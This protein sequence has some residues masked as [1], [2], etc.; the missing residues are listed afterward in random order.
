MEA[1]SDVRMKA[2]GMEAAQEDEAMVEGIRGKLHGQE[3]DPALVQLGQDAELMQRLEVLKQEL[4]KEKD[5]TDEARMEKITAWMDTHGIAEADLEQAISRM[6]SAVGDPARAPRLLP[7]LRGTDWER[8]A[9][10]TLMNAQSELARTDPKAALRAFE[11][12]APGVD[13]EALRNAQ[14]SYARD[15]SKARRTHLEN[16]F[17]VEEYDA[18]NE[19]YLHGTRD[20]SEAVRAWREDAL[21]AEVAPQEHE[22]FREKLREAYTK[23]LEGARDEKDLAER[24]ATVPSDLLPAAKVLVNS[25]FRTQPGTKEQARRSESV[26]SVLRDHPEALVED[27]SLVHGAVFTDEDRGRVFKALA[28]R[29]E[30]SPLVG[31]FS[32]DRLPDDLRE[33][34][35]PLI[36]AQRLRE[37]PASIVSELEQ[38]RQEFDALSEEQRLDIFR[39]AAGKDPKAVLAQ[40]DAIPSGDA[41]K[42]IVA[43]AISRIASVDFRFFKAQKDR[44]MSLPVEE[45]ARIAD[46]WL[47]SEGLRGHEVLPHLTWQASLDKLE[48]LQA[49]AANAEHDPWRT[50]LEPLLTEAAHAGVIDTH[51]EADG[52]IVVDFVKQFGMLNMPHVFDWHAALSR[53]KDIK[54]LAPD[55]RADLSAFLGRPVEKLPNKGFI[56]Q[57]IKRVSAEL[58]QALL[59]G[60]LSAEMLRRHPAC[61]EMV[62]AAIGTTMWG[63]GRNFADLQEKWERNVAAHPEQLGLPEG[64]ETVRLEVAE[65]ERGRSRSDDEKKEKIVNNPD[66]KRQVEQWQAS[67][68]ESVRTPGKLLNPFTDKPSDGEWRGAMAEMMREEIA[69]ELEELGQKADSLPNEKARQG[70]EKKRQELKRVQDAISRALEPGPGG[71]AAPLRP[72]TDILTEIAS[73]PKSFSKKGELLRYISA[74]HMQGLMS[75]ERRQLAY[76]DDA[77]SWNSLMVDYVNEHYLNE[78]QQ[79]DHTGHEPF[80]PKTLEALRFAWGL[81]K[82]ETNPVLIAAERLRE[83]EQGKATGKTKTVDLVPVTGLMRITAGDAGDACY[84]SKHDGL[85]EGQYPDLQAFVFVTGRGT[86]QERIQGSVLAVETV[87]DAGNKTLVVRANNPRMSLLSAVDPAQLI[88]QTLEALKATAARRGIA[89]VVVP[90]DAASSSCSNRA[91][92]ADHY[93]EMYGQGSLAPAAIVGLRRQPETEFN[94]YDNWDKYGHHPVVRI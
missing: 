63:R 44:V 33:E 6:E 40:E 55:V 11:R 2:M 30:K 86:P 50:D 12:S 3:Q 13:E 79:P 5:L 48:S 88:A 64:Y 31:R 20:P 17:T 16:L 58:R 7:R 82:P 28:R 10:H 65:V 35:R 18:F 71:D 61:E 8:S 67:F 29:V 4:Q 89:Q 41:R 27:G 62:G 94:G 70:L 51:N 24:L 78:G 1:A 23:R 22:A 90:L 69:R 25:A 46:G 14:E 39:I 36:F 45:Q 26:V 84:T 75:D 87:D 54:D 80:D 83:L 68:F 60:T 93:A 37:A 32:P 56:L 76:K 74:R 38:F 92:V 66:V 81:S 53:A 9:V 73:L 43:R 57:E 19:Q 42:D 72:W 21:W 15:F 77:K 49:H 59:D 91:D 52:E 85:A 47:L 34:A